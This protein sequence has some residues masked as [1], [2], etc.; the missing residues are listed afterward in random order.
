[1]Y[2][3]SKASYISYSVPPYL[4]PEMFVAIV[5]Y[6]L[7]FPTETFQLSHWL[8]FLGLSTYMLKKTKTFEPSTTHSEPFEII[9]LFV[10]RAPNCNSSNTAG[11]GVN[12]PSSTF[13]PTPNNFK[14]L[15]WKDC[16]TQSGTFQSPK[17]SISASLKAYS[18]TASP[19]YT[20]LTVSGLWLD[21]IEVHI[22]IK[23]QGHF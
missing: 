19:R 18:E 11:W 21:D 12:E 16:S 13:R 17:A 23:G 3:P 10:G 15:R 22:K 1:M 4:L 6:G 2:I 9:A 8:R 7:S 20:K 5:N 14:S